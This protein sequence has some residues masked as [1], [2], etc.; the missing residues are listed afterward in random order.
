LVGKTGITGLEYAQSTLNGNL[1]IPPRLRTALHRQTCSRR[2]KQTCYA[3]YA[4][5]NKR[6]SEILPPPPPHPCRDPA[7]LAELPDDAA[8]LTAEA[9]KVLKAVYDALK[10]EDAECW[11]HRLGAIAFKYTSIDPD[12]VDA[13][14]EAIK[15][16]VPPPPASNDDHGKTFP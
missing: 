11:L 16:D 14:W 7:L 10:T 12:G 1:P 2:Y 4:R 8:G 13:A 6:L 5:R 15:A 3:R 9:K